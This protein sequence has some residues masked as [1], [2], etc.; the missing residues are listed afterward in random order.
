MDWAALQACPEHRLP[1]NPVVVDEEAIEKCVEELTSAIQ[2]AT[3][4]WAPRRRPRDDPRPPL[5]ASIQDEVCLKNRLRRQWQI[6]RDPAL[7]ARI[8]RLQR[9]VTYQMNEW[10]NDQCS[11]ALESLCSEDQSLWKT[12]KRVKRIPTPSPPLQV[13][14]G[15]AVSDSEKAEVLADS[16]EAQFQPVDDPSYPAFTE[17]VDVA[18]RTY[19]FAPA[20]EPTLT[21]PSEVLQTIKGLKVGKAPDPNGIPNRVPR[22][23]PKDALT[24]LT[25]VFNAVLLRKYSPPVRKHARVVPIV[26]QGRTDAALFLQTDKSPGHRWQTL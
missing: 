6:T 7:K 14:G 1:G 15:L 17:T 25:K 24:V 4:A 20:S 18:M 2:E 21:T 5:A 22:H 23:L 19:E 11:H 16:L 26:K 13:P 9:S 8:N 10:R 3:E 12:T